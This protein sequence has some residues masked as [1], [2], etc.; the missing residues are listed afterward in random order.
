MNINIIVDKK[1]ETARAFF[2]KVKTRLGDGGPWF[3]R[4][5]KKWNLNEWRPG[6]YV[7]SF[8]FIYFDIYLAG[9]VLWILAFVSSVLLNF[10][11]WLLYIPGLVVFSTG[12][13]Y[14]P[15]FWRFMLKKGL[16]KAGYTGPIEAL[17]SS[18][19]L[20]L[21]NETEARISVK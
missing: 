13:F 4:P 19:A 16:R 21:I 14:T 20:S 8:E 11:S 17:S 15:L 7:L 6:F 3:A 1:D 12:L 5:F 2:K 18:K 9:P 10:Y